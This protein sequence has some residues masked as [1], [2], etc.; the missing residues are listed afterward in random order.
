MQNTAIA[1]MSGL[2]TT[3]SIL[4]YGT[5]WDIITG[6]DLMKDLKNI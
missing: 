2:I 6:R 5:L 3:Y 1:L 4:G